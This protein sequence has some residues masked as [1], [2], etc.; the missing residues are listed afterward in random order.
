MNDEAKKFR[1]KLNYTTLKIPE[2]F[3]MQYTPVIVCIDDDISIGETIEKRLPSVLCEVLSIDDLVRGID[4]R[5]VGLFEKNDLIFID[6]F[7]KDK[8]TNQYA[9]NYFDMYRNLSRETVEETDGKYKVVVSMDEL[10][11]RLKRQ[12]SSDIY[13]TDENFNVSALSGSIKKHPR[14]GYRSNS[15]KI[16]KIVEAIEEYANK[17]KIYLYK[18]SSMSF[19]EWVQF[20]KSLINKVRDLVQN[21]QEYRTIED[22]ENIISEFNDIIGE[23][24]DVLGLEKSGE[25]TIR[26]ISDAIQCTKKLCRQTDIP[27]KKLMDLGI[28]TRKIELCNLSHNINNPLL[29]AYGVCYQTENEL[30]KETINHEQQIGE[31]KA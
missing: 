1:E 28:K 15:S 22:I 19:E 20:I 26:S 7:Y 23:T 14:I 18:N 17:N 3:D 31:T 24:N 10:E 9:I 8:E 5:M 25:N 30:K 21:L 4:K 16:E 12:T 13:V 6:T 11:E 2:G 29:Y 27:R